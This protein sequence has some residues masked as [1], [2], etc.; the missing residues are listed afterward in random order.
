MRVNLVSYDYALI[1]IIL[2]QEVNMSSWKALRLNLIC[3]KCSNTYKNPKL[4]PCLDLICADCLKDLLTATTPNPSGRKKDVQCPNCKATISV[5][6]RVEELPSDIYTARLIEVLNS[7][8][9]LKCQNC[10][11]DAALYAI[12]SKC[13]ILLCEVCTEA[14][15][16]AIKTQKH[17][18]LLVNEMRSSAGAIPTVLFEEDEN[19]PIHPTKLLTFYCK[20]EGELLCEQCVR[21][22]HANHDPVCC[23]Y[24]LLYA[25]LW[26]GRTALPN[27]R[28]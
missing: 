27:A 10:S 3:A 18:L 5:P 4:L 6:L 9:N 21:E 23:M 16:R 15:K 11:K 8:S 7:K 13:K 12:C 20:R 28:V 26:H 17:E 14:H 1:K 24:V 25:I 2:V 19:C 22:K